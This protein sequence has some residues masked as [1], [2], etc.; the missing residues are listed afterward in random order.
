MKLTLKNN[1]DYSIKSG[2]KNKI[3][4]DKN[5][6]SNYSI[7]RP[8]CHGTNIAIK[9]LKKLKKKT[10]S[11]YFSF[12]N[13]IYI[14][15]NFI[16][17]I[18]KNKAKIVANKES[19]VISSISYDK[20]K[21][22]S[23]SSLK[24]HLHHISKIVGNHKYLKYPSLILSIKIEFNNMNFNSVIIKKLRKNI[25]NLD[26]C[27]KNIKSSTLFAKLYRKPKIKFKDLKKK[28]IEKVL[29]FGKNSDLGNYTGK[30]LSSKGYKV[31]YFKKYFTHNTILN[32]KNL[33]RYKEKKIDY[34]FY[35]ISS[36]ISPFKKGYNFENYYIFKLICNY[37]LKN[38]SCKI[39]FP[40]TKFINK[41]TSEYFNYIQSKLKTENLITRLNNNN[42]NNNIKFYR[43]PQFKTSQ[44]Y[45][46]FGKY[47][48]KNLT[49][50]DTY[51][52][53]FISN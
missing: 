51:I 52:N 18:Y 26:M 17:K 4:F 8:I 33:S 5:F 15:D 16:F 11:I 14:N 6:S 30:Y 31:F 9:L 22:L 44:T 39:F 53:K 36:K 12:Q 28:K 13:P 47:S 25:Y 43:L 23:N 37:F 24:K 27:S 7:K 21:I 34:I 35:F 48:G 2:D 40:S 41:P 50:I 38:S 49:T 32:K 42:N 1:R 46:L 29:I 45:N 20:K 19:K 3:H 10:T